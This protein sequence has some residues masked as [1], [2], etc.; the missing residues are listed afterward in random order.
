MSIF[1]LFK[2]KEK[3][4][5]TADVNDTIAD[6]LTKMSKYNIGCMLIT[7]KGKLAGIF[8]ERDLLRKWIDI[9]PL[10][11]AKKPIS[12]IM[13]KKPITLDVEKSDKASVFMTAHKFRHLPITE[14][15]KL[16]DILSIRDVLHLLM[17]ENDRLNAEIKK[18]KK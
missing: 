2:N 7:D 14:N 11:F 5:E 18:L 13:T 10:I 8:T 4:I 12:E 6:V 3:V 16:V 9:Y 15:G 1:D 17:D